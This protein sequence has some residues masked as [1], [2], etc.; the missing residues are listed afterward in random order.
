M[1]YQSGDITEN[2]ERKAVL[3][4]AMLC[5]LARRPSEMTDP[6]KREVSSRFWLV[7]HIDDTE[8]QCS[9]MRDRQFEFISL[10]FAEKRDADWRQD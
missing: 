4:V 8:T 10:R 7:N 1:V 5:F 9:A 6:S 3:P 2:R